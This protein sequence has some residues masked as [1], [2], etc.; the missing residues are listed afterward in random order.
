MEKREVREA[1]REHYRET[2]QFARSSDQETLE[3]IAEH[4]TIR[5]AWLRRAEISVEKFGCVEGELL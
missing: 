4:G 3:S 5:P 2:S 1:R